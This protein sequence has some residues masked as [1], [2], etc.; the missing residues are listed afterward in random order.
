MSLREQAVFL[1]RHL[2]HVT[3]INIIMVPVP[4]LVCRIRNPVEVHTYGV[5]QITVLFVPR[6]GSVNQI[7]NVL[8]E[9]DV[10]L[11]LVVDIVSVVLDLAILIVIVVV[12]QLVIM[13]GV[14]VIW[15]RGLREGAVAPFTNIVQTLILVMLFV[16]VGLHLLPVIVLVVM[17]LV[18]IEA[19]E[20]CVLPALSLIAL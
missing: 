13:E 10:P 19:G 6:Q 11:L 18:V 7:L 4:T 5:A 1:E 12:P 20:V 17:V 3:R 2:V 8:Q 15:V 9:Q 16:T 14:F